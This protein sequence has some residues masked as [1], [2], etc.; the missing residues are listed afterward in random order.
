MSYIGLK[1]EEIVLLEE[2]YGK[3]EFSA[4]K[5]HGFLK[6]VWDI[7]REPMF[8]ILL[9]ACL[10]YFILGEITE[11]MLMA[12]AMVFVSA[13]SFYEEIKSANALAALRQYTQPVI[14]V[15]RDGKEK[16]I[17]SRDLLPGDVMLVEEGNLIPADASILQSND[18][19]I[20][21]SVISGESL[22]VDKN[23][24]DGANRLFQ[25]STVNSG[26]CVA[27]VTAI[28][29]STDLGKLGRSISTITISKT[30]LQKQIGQFVRAMAMIGIIIFCLIWLVNYLHTR[31][32]IQSLLLGLT[33]AMAIIPEEIPVAFSSFMALGAMHMTKLGIITRQPQTIEN[34]GAVSVLCLDKTGTITENRMEVRKVYDFE[35]GIMEEEKEG[36][37][38]ESRDLLRYARL[39][40]EGDPFDAMEKAI[41]GAYKKTQGDPAPPDAV[42]GHAKMLHEYPLGGHPPMMT[43]LYE[44]EGACIVAGKGAPERILQVCRLDPPT[45]KKIDLIIEQMASEGFRV[46]GICAARCKEGDYPEDQS[47]FNWQ[48]KGLV[49]LYDPP[50]K[51]VKAEF[52]KWHR[53]GIKIKLVTGDFG[54][55]AGNIAVQVGLD[56]T[57]RVL[58]GEEIM[59]MDPD[60]LHRA[61]GESSIF[62]R[63]FPDAKLKLI[64]ALKDNGE[65]VAMMGDGVNDGPA[66]RASHIGIAMGGKGTEI[67]KQ[68][69]GLI[70]T[71]DDLGK[72]TEAIRQGRK[73]YHNLKKAVR[74]IVSIH[75]PIIL[76]ASVPL[77]LNWK[78]PN[79]FTPIHV[80]FLELIMGPTCSVFFENEP[81]EPG[82][83]KKPP[84]SRS[85]AIFT[86]RELLTSVLQGMVIAAG[87]LGLYYYFMAGGASLSYI[88]TVVFITLIISN[89]FLTFVNRSFEENIFRTMRYKNSL[90]RYVV[91]AS[92]V[93]LGCIVS[94]PFVRGLFELTI[95]RTADYGLSLGVAMVITLWFEGYKTLKRPLPNDAA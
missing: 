79:I 17:L 55:T 30:Q 13:I 25:G 37:C 44:G 15:I 33:L 81:V 64:E 24:S 74:Y 35:R 14:A 57:G 67:A 4:D 82:M 92:L 10:L 63:M 21:E 83:M 65:I 22:P 29:N 9:I 90:T 5:D 27:R 53:A 49:A 50:K 52:E 42:A 40:S 68:A 51:G 2:K 66:L 78:F 39:A 77:L 48:F 11:G 58:T 26:K 69:A 34:L 46:L 75:V 1:Q 16:I 80:I 62:A 59:Q 8:V 85:N 70:L 60:E 56:V 6:K 84:R 20:N 87:I 86:A 38:F 93:F 23:A 73:I 95:L 54:E 71:D 91:M 32:L 19:S 36:H 61:A 72:V 3:N 12:A 94:I 18:L 89:I 41:L 43:H 88:R 28:G 31:E 45:R 76:T 7:A 47:D